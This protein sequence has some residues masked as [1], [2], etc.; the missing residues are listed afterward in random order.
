V[1]P[2]KLERII[3]DLVVKGLGLDLSDPNLS[4]TPARISEM[5]Q[6]IFQNV[7]KEY[8]EELI[9]WFPNEEIPCVKELVPH[10]L[11]RT[12]SDIHYIKYTYNQLILFPK[13]HFTSWCAH[14]FLPFDGEAWFGYIPKEKLV[15]AS[16]PARLMEWYSKRPQM[17][18]TL[19]N[20]VIN[21]FD[22]AIKP[23]GT[24]LLIYGVHDCMRCR[25]VKSSGGMFTSA[26]S[27]VL[28]TD[29][30]ARSEAM[31]L[32]KISMMR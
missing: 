23:Q 28:S 27:G 25:G 19:C 5:Y 12:H 29:A 18:E 13:I 15:G 6:D 26:V 16:K 1:D 30:K 3:K 7:G 14:H 9:T 8:P 21:R 4:N 31:D 32:I 22:E 2:I 24:I 10:E 20:D 11:G 17:Q